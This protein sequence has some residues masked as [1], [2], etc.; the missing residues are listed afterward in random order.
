MAHVSGPWMSRRIAG[1]AAHLPSRCCRVWLA[2]MTIWPPE[3]DSL[4]RPAYAAIADAAAGAIRA[5]LL[6]PGARLPTHRRLAADLGV[7]VQTI[8]RAYEELIRRG[9]VAGEV[10]RGTYVLGQEDEAGTPFSAQRLQDGVI[11]LSMIRP[12]TGTEHL[13]AFTRALRAIAAD[14]P[15]AVATSFRPA[16]ALY[17]CHDAAE[18][19]LQLCGLPI[20]R[21]GL[22]FTNGATAG[23]ALALAGTT[24]PGGAVL[25]DPLT[26]HGL[27]GLARALHLRLLAVAGDAEGMRP[28]ALAAACRNSGATAVFLM[29]SGLG[30]EAMTM[31]EERRRQLAATA[32]RHDLFIVEND[33]WGPLQPGRP[34]PVT[35]HAR[36]R[37]LYVTSL[38][39]CLLPGLR[40][41]FLV[42]PERLEAAITERDMAL[43]WMATPL[44]AH[45]AA[46]WIGD[47]T[48][49]DLLQRQRA[50]MAERNAIAARSLAGVPFR[51]SVNGMH[52]W[53]PLSDTAAEQ[54]LVAEARVNGVAV[55]G[56]EAFRLAEGHPPAPGVR[57]CLGTEEAA[58]LTQGL[59]ILARVLRGQTLPGRSGFVADA[60][61]PR[62]P[63][64]SSPRDA[65]G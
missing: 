32:R 52:I 2:T 51:S 47:H 63:D 14:C 35:A 61:V 56:T 45:V 29:P 36:E 13:D 30:P 59:R 18:R 19:W 16:S 6:R 28:D 42:V 39:K 9:M 40:L 46:R 7:S 64:S 24:R 26:H 50:A 41:G 58:T 4:T 48:A 37:G 65:R 21:Q 33:A 60:T 34:A 31:G 38:T 1:Q 62:Y 44:M 17:P 10:G 8:S 57:I 25:A 27:I 20:E 5:G 11:D 54:A 49:D 53:V 12:V 15:P 23:L 43:H 22:V 55:S 3:R